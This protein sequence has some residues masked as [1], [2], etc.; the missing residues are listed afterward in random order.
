MQFLLYQVRD[1]IFFIFRSIAV[2]ANTVQLSVHTRGSRLAL[3]EKP[4]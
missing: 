2:D 1:D 4:P 3:C